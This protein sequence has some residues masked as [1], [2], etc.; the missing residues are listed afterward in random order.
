[1]LGT[2]RII[3]NAHRPEDSRLNIYHRQFYRTKS[4]NYRG[5]LSI[6]MQTSKETRFGGPVWIAFCLSI[7]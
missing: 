4:E 6:H 3:G 1:M 5:Q 2:I 7:D